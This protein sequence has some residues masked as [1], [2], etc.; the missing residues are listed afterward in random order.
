MPV[1]YTVEAGGTTFTLTS[2]NF[3]DL[4]VGVFNSAQADLQVGCEADIAGLTAVITFSSATASAKSRGELIALEFVPP[5]F[6]I[7]TEE[8]SKR[9]QAEVNSYERAAAYA[10]AQA[11]AGPPAPRRMT[12]ESAS[13][14]PDEGARRKMM[15]DSIRAAVKTRGTGEKREMGMLEKVECKGRDMMLSLKTQAGLVKLS[16]SKNPEIMLFVQDLAGAQFGC[17]M[18]PIEFPAV[19]IY[20]DKPNAKAKTVGEIVYLAFMPTSFTL[21]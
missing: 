15:M 12:V 10:E 4:T 8:E 11:A 13:G 17:G 18:K 2:K 3:Q 14:M 21:E 7:L 16:A 5:D 6:R 1:S 9:L 20:A 19:F